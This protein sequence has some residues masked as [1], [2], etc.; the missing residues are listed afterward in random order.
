M[1]ELEGPEIVTDPA[2]FPQSFNEPASLAVFVK[3][4]K[5][6]PVHERIGREPLVVK[7]LHEIGQYGGT[8][9]RGFTGP[10]DTSAGQR[11]NESDHLTYFDYTATKV[12]PNIGDSQ[13][14]SMSTSTR[15][16]GRHH[17]TP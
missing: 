17:R 3:S 10:V 2:Q 8:W 6:P 9:R 13:A 12:V 4:G 7:P 1:G 16:D 5:L 14:L 11:V 15:Q